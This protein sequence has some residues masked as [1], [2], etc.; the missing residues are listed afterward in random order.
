MKKKNW[1]LRLIFISFIIFLGLYIA[2]IS[3]YYESQ[4]S[5][6]VAITNDAIKEF[7]E[8]VL[9]GKEVDIKTYIV[10]E[11]KDYSNKITE[12]GD[13]ITGAVEKIIT[14]GFGGVWDAIKV[15]FF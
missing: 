7:E 4:I 11:N 10:D 5:N 12:T 3:G 13:K 2:S 6:K 9:N 14:D 8:D 1:F 15:L